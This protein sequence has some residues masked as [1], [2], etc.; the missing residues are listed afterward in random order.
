MPE[1]RTTTDAL[2]L[3]DAPTTAG[4]VL[5]TIRRG[6]A[7]YDLGE[8]REAGGRTWR[9]VAIGPVGWVADEYL[10]EPG[11]TPGRSFDPNTPTELQVQN[12]TCSIRSMIWL[13]KSLG[14]AVT[15]A[16]AQ[17]VMAPRFVNADVGLRD[18][19][20]AGVVQALRE[21]WGVAARNQNPMSFDE[22][23]ALAG[24]VPL[25]IGGR[26]WGHWTAVRGFDG[27]SLIL[28]NPGGTGPRYGQQTLNR[29]QFHQLGPFSGVW[30]P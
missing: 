4:H 30:V 19:S 26:N 22:V 9:K 6:R 16:E 12:W 17:D 1:K 14:I 24:H 18:A 28:A 2:N 21:H 25:M 3:R 5:E 13:L 27:E 7:V 20:G 10:S 29:D 11:D 15:P 8:T 23:A